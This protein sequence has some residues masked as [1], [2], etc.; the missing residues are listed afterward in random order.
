[1][2]GIRF[3]HVFTVLLLLS[4]LSAFVFPRRTSNLRSHV[5]GIFYP[6]AKPA[7]MIASTIRGRMDGP[8]DTRPAD[9]I[10]AENR[11]LK[12]SL[13]NL[14]GQVAGLQAR[15][16]EMERF[17]DLAPLCKRVP[18]MGNDPAARDSLSVLG[19]FEP[20]LVNQPALY[21]DGLAG[22]FERAGKSGAQIRLVTDRSFSVTG[23]F[24]TF[25]DDS[26]GVMTFSPKKTELPLVEGQGR[27]VMMIRNVE[28]AELAKAQIGEG[29]WVVLEDKDFPPILQHVKLGRVVSIKKRIEAPLWADVEVR[30]EWNLMGLESVMVFNK[31]GESPTRMTQ[32]E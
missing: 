27:G 21:F 20:S 23:R 1:M 17:G 10:I 3:N 12:M 7:R 32:A 13:A 30:P 25:I 8:K 18:V 24:G 5:Q 22:T 29:H 2:S 14:S 28:V 26:N 31:H 9:D 11:R 16:A 15:V 4:L 6:V 19:A